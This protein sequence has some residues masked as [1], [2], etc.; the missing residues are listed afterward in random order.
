MLPN[1]DHELCYLFSY[2]QSNEGIRAKHW[3]EEVDL[4]KYGGQRGWRELW[5]VDSDKAG[6]AWQVHVVDK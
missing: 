1:T 5:P 4:M 3:M 6:A 2:R